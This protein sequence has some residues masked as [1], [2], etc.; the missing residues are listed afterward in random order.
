M[1]LGVVSAST[2]TV[3]N[4][5]YQLLFIV[6]AFLNGLNWHNSLLVYQRYLSKFLTLLLVAELLGQYSLYIYSF[7]Q[8]YTMREKYQREVTGLLFNT[9]SF[10]VFGLKV[11]LFMLE[12]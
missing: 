10:V 7:S 11:L 2:I 6:Q 5:P 3:L 9:T 12:C 4:A 8:E 1:T